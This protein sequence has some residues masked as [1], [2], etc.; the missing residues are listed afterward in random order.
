LHLATRQFRAQTQDRD[1]HR[2]G[3]SS[4]ICAP[5]L[6]D[7][8]YAQRKPDSAEAR[9]ACSAQLLRLAAAVEANEPPRSA[10]WPVSSRV[11]SATLPARSSTPLGV[12]PALRV[13][14]RSGPVAPRAHG[15][16]TRP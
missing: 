14:A 16:S 10:S 6:L 9:G 12:R 15:P 13:P 3:F 2:L 5:P 8:A 1:R 11:H 7:G 4:C